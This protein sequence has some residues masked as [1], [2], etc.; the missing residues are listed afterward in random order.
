MLLSTDPRPTYRLTV[1]AI[2]MLGGM[3]LLLLAL[4][5]LQIGQSQT[6]ETKVR[7]Q[8]TKSIILP[9]AR[10]L[11]TDRWGIPLAELR[12]SVDIDL[13]LPEIRSDYF[14][15]YRKV[16]VKFTQLRRGGVL[17]SER[18]YDIVKIVEDRIKPL[19][20]I[21]GNR[22]DYE[23]R[24]LE[25][26]QRIREN[27][28]FQ[29]KSDLSF[30]EIS[31]LMEHN[32]K[33]PGVE[34]TPRPMRRYSYG[35]TACHVL[36][37]TGR[38]EEAQILER[39]GRKIELDVIGKEGVEA[40]WDSY[41]QGNPGFRTVE[42]NNLGHVQ[43]LLEQRH[44][45]LGNSV[46]LTIDLRVQQIVERAMAGVGRGACVVLDCNTGDVL[47]MASVPNFDPNVIGTPEGWKAAS[48]NEARPLFNRAIGAYAPGSIFK[49][50]V[51]LAALKYNSVSPTNFK[52]VCG[53]G[54]TVADR[55]KKCWS[56]GKG[57]CGSQD[58]VGAI[59][60]SC[61]VYFY[62]IGMKTGITHV[63]EVAETLGLGRIAG[64]PVR[65]ESPGTIPSLEWMKKNY[66]K[67]RW[68]NGHMA[69]MAIGQGYVQVTPLQMANV[70]ASIANGGTV[71][72][73]RLVSQVTD[74]TGQIVRS[75]PVKIRGRLDI[76]PEKIEVVRRGMRE[77]VNGS[78]GTAG[79]AKLEDQVVAGKTG[80]AQFTTRFRGR[81]VKDNR[82]WF[83]AFA[84]YESPRYAI[85][86]MVEGGE[87]GGRTSAPIVA[88]VFRGIFDLEK[89]VSGFQLVYMPVNNGHFEG[90]KELTPEEA[91]AVGILM[92]NVPQGQPVP[93]APEDPSPEPEETTDTPAPAPPPSKPSA[94]P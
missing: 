94:R 62:T 77:V 7:A 54:M 83:I 88:E 75:E 16:P 61:N 23:P 49:P 47:A 86:V 19:R 10:G 68:S 21:L 25:L 43:R 82:T 90:L 42:I 67:D 6:Y 33:I 22:L 46:Y 53:G 38:P 60:R 35:S 44:P 40:T 81:T 87:S 15:Q 76:P 72:Y 65:G 11:V 78:G 69:N 56:F 52:T 80:T 73:P 28:P 36:G 93:A 41:L 84:P 39:E 70:A 74:A 63:H 5:H 48:W 37:F 13:Y 2:I 57:G 45:T 26:H 64:L 79:R 31:E 8:S 58:M 29:L 32:P 34:I 24:T 17:K 14:Q 30:K 91:V 59:R 55:Y 50:I 89:A 27:L 20:A 51:A 85:C 12:P 4:Y 66:P 71:Y 3:L 92:P 18:E 9:P 1:L